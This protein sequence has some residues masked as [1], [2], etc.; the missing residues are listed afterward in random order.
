MRLGGPIAGFDS[1]CS[2]VAEVHRRG[3]RAAYC[4][5]G[6]GADRGTIAAYAAAA[7]EA[8]I[9]IAE[10]GAWSNPLAPDPRER[11]AALD[12]CKRSLAL[13]EAIGARCCVNIAGSRGTKWDGPDP[14]D[15]TNDT[16]AMIVSTVREIIDAVGPSQTYYTLE[17]MPWMYPDSPDSYLELIRAIDRESFGVHLDFANMINSPSRFFA[18]GEFVQDCV[19]KLMPHIRSSHVKDVRQGDGFPIQLDEVRPGMGGL[20]YSAI[21]RELDHVDGD[22]PIMLEHLPD[23]D[24]YGLA[25][26][27]VRSVAGMLGIAL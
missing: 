4:P 14:R 1:P 18:S 13:A 26:D 9:V 15:L 6:V 23:Q 3:Y 17:T 21:L 24:A 10:V 20:D 16:F 2:W 22:L 8:D 27:Y 19:N 12:K 11:D 7:A 5:V 25:A